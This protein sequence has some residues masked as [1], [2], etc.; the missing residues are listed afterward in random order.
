VRFVLLCDSILFMLL[1]FGVVQGIGRARVP[2]GT[3]MAGAL[4]LDQ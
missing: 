3:D 2:H 1:S 4:Y